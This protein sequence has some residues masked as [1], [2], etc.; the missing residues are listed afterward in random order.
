MCIQLNKVAKCSYRVVASH[1]MLCNVH[2]QLSN[3]EVT[4]FL[5]LKAHDTKHVPCVFY[6]VLLAV[7]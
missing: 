4:V 6:I 7:N 5:K 3:L 1:L 2:D